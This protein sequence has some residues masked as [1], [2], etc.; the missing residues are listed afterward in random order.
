MGHPARSPF[1]RIDRILLP[2]HVEGC[3]VDP[4]IGPSVPFRQ[5][6]RSFGGVGVNPE[7]VAVVDEQLFPGV[8]QRVEMLDE[9][10]VPAFARFGRR[11]GKL[12]PGR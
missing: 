12:G 4:W 2:P 10:L 8:T 1:T 9:V 6:G 7:G 5:I 11:E 3:I